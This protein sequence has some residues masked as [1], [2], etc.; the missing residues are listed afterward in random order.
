MN[1][2]VGAFA[3]LACLSVKI[4]APLWQVMNGSVPQFL[5]CQKGITVIFTLEGSGGD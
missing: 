5:T 2:E 3:E 1:K 4:Q